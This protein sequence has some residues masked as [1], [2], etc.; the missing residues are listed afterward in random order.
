MG[1]PIPEFQ[2]VVDVTQTKPAPDQCG[3]DY[4]DYRGCTWT[5]STPLYNWASLIGFC[6]NGPC[7]HEEGSGCKNWIA[8]QGYKLGEVRRK[9]GGY[10]TLMTSMEM[11]STFYPEQFPETPEQTE[12][13]RAKEWADYYSWLR[14]YNEKQDIMRIRRQ[15][16]SQ[17]EQQ[18]QAMRTEQEN[19]V[20]ARAE[21]EKE[22]RIRRNERLKIAATLEDEYL[23]PMNQR[24]SRKR[25]I[26]WLRRL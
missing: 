3:D 7:A 23:K 21:R 18:M 20:A 1:N 22:Q 25:V 13:R 26:E 14:Q 9:V 2:P 16:Q 5:D 24:Q 12:A 8:V 11:L 10:A 6:E 15:V 19:Y 4:V 17:Q